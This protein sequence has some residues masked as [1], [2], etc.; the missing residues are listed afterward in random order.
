MCVQRGAPQSDSLRHLILCQLRRC[1]F[2]VTVTASDIATGGAAM[3]RMSANTSRSDVSG[4][5][6]EEGVDVLLWVR[7]VMAVRS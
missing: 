4:L 1:G 5:E 3:Q 7:A 2:T 6:T